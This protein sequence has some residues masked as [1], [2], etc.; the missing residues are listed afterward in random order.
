MIHLLLL[1]RQSDDR[2]TCDLTPNNW[3]FIMDWCQNVVWCNL[4]NVTREL[5]VYSH[6]NFHIFENYTLLSYFTENPTHQGIKKINYQLLKPQVSLFMSCK[7][8]EGSFLG[9]C[10]HS[11]TSRIKNSSNK[12]KHPSM[13]CTSPSRGVKGL[14]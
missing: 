4:N 5:P 12:P 14:L 1:L 3:I 9:P 11:P 8:R 2:A 10:L 6:I 7:I 13:R